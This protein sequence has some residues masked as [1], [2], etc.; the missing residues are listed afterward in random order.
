MWRTP[1]PKESQRALTPSR[2]PEGFHFYSATRL[3][4]DSAA[5]KGMDFTTAI[6]SNSLRL[7][8]ALLADTIEYHDGQGQF[9]YF[10]RAK[11]LDLLDHRPKDHVHHVLRYTSVIPWRMLRFDREMAAVV[12]YEEWEDKLSREV[13][14]YSFCRLYFFDDQGKINNFVFT[15]R[16]VHPVGRYPLV[17]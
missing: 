10:D 6:Y 4:S 1:W 5:K 13:S 17:E 2:T 15:R 7:Q 16:R 11:V 3:G 14:V 12:T 8:Q 9:G